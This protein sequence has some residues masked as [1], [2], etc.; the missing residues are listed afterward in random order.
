MIP[1]LKPNPDVI[2]KAVSAAKGLGHAVGVGRLGFAGGGGLQGL[3]QQLREQQAEG[4]QRLS[5]TRSRPERLRSQGNANAT[6]GNMPL[7]LPSSAPPDPNGLLEGNNGG[8]N[9]GQTISN[10]GDI[11]NAVSNAT[12]IGKAPPPR[13]TGNLQAAQAGSAAYGK[14]NGQAVDTASKLTQHLMDTYGWNHDQAVG[15][16]GVLGYESGNFQNLQELPSAANN[17][18]KG[19]RGGYGFAQWTGPRRAAFEQYAQQNNLDPASYE[20]NQGFLDAELQGQYKRVVPMM[21]SAPDRDTAAKTFLSAYEGMPPNSPVGVPATAGHVAAA[22]AYDKALSATANTNNGPAAA[23]AASQAQQPA[24]VL[25]PATPVDAAPGANPSPDNQDPTA[26]RRGGH[27]IDRAVKI[28]RRARAD[29]GGFDMSYYDVSNQ[30][31]PYYT[32]SLALPKPGA[33][34]IV[35][36][37]SANPGVTASGT[38]TPAISYAQALAA[39]ATNA[40][41][42]A[43]AEGGP[44]PVAD[45]PVNGNHGGYHPPSQPVFNNSSDY[46]GNTSYDPFVG[47]AP[48]PPPRPADLGSGDGSAPASSGGADESAQNSDINSVLSAYNAN[49]SGS[50]GLGAASAPLPPPRPADLATNN[51]LTPSSSGLGGGSS[52]AAPAVPTPPPRA[53]PYDYSGSDP[54]PQVTS[55]PLPG[56]VSDIT[57]GAIAPAPIAPSMGP[58]SPTQALAGAMTQNTTGQPT[59]LEQG[60]GTQAL[61]EAMTATPLPSPPPPASPNITL[62]VDPMQFDEA[63]PGAPAPAKVVTP[64]ATYGTDDGLGDTSAPM[65]TATRVISNPDGTPIGDL[66]PSSPNGSANVPGTQISSGDV[67]SGLS[68]QSMSDQQAQAFSGA[69]QQQQTFS[70]VYGQTYATQAEADAGQ[71]KTQDSSDNSSGNSGDSSGGSG[72]GGDNKRGGYIKPKRAGGGNVEAALAMLRRKSKASSDKSN[73]VNKALKIARRA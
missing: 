50:K 46:S 47:D 58:P 12:G 53:V 25:P 63:T 44:A 40:A 15:A 16:V 43:S 4:E 49:T 73:V 7:S 11:G 57:S 30:N 19:G 36:N 62:D 26:A 56:S 5:D 2:G 71:D 21:A 41:P 10:L 52:P 69:A 72:G 34:P 3:T 68:A 6:M 59:P 65:K 37:G 14:L 54:T 55:T 13:A 31:S 9:V 67:S 27:I 22:A 70:D 23:P 8:A 60:W 35:T 29:G 48:T 38:G 64:D 66:A 39:S 61:R 51:S 42:A 32:P 45:A 33:L 20:A 28:A 18:L 24:S 1:T 17:Y